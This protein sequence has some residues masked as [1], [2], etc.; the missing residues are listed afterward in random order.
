MASVSGGFAFA[1]VDGLGIPP[2]VRSLCLL[3]LF[4]WV[5]DDGCRG[6]ILVVAAAT[7]GGFYWLSQHLCWRLVLVVSVGV[8]VAV[9]S[10]GS[11]VFSLGFVWSGGLAGPVVGFHG[12]CVE[13]FLGVSGRVVPLG[14]GKSFAWT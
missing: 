14:G 2:G 11:R 10:I 6:W 3:R 5:A 1:A 9:S 12:G 13:V 4:E 7:L 8:D